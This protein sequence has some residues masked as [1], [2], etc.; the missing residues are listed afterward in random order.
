MSKTRKISFR[1]S[2]SQQKELSELD[3]RF[4]LSKL[5]R[6]ALDAVIKNIKEGYT[7]NE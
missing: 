6:E 1:A 3:K 2:E 5:L 4:N 7:V